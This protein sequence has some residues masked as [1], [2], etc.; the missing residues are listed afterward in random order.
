MI[1][2]RTLFFLFVLIPWLGVGQPGSHLD[3]L[4]YAQ[5]PDEIKLLSIT[6]E[7]PRF[8]KGKYDLRNFL[9]IFIDSTKSLNYIESS[10][11]EYANSYV[12]LSEV[13]L[14][15]LSKLRRNC[16]LRLTVQS[17]LEGEVT[18]LTNFMEAEVVTY[19]T[20]KTGK[21]RR[22]RSGVLVP[23][24][25]RY[26]NKQYGQLAALPITLPAGHGQTY[27]WQVRS[28]PVFVETEHGIDLNFNL[29][30]PSYLSNFLQLDV[31][32]LGLS[33]GFL[34]AV[35]TYH[36]VIF[37]YSQD[38]NY[39][40]FFVFCVATAWFTVVNLGYDLQYLWPEQPFAHYYCIRAVALIVWALVLLVFSQSYL[41]LPRLLPLWNKI[42][43]GVFGVAAVGFL[44]GTPLMWSNP[45]WG[46]IL[47]RLGQNA[48]LMLALLLQHSIPV[49]DGLPPEPNGV[50]VH[51][52]ER[53]G[54][55]QK[56]T[57]II[58]SNPRSFPN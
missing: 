58:A 32:V 40:W 18:W 4:Q 24:S 39:L 8:Q 53:V 7:D 44:V 55:I 22:L 28:Q 46:L 13:S 47:V 37:L 9:Y 11:P 35:G 33:L 25:E 43:W 30:S 29:L 14:V 49:N 12:P 52:S 42:L 19:T 26:F 2:I 16:W 17:S 34:I 41:Q 51:F 3:A 15:D 54:P 56:Q 6:M 31:M 20:T 23:A 38:W 57:T 10:S 45:S 21:V 1:K 36:F 27:Y 50:A 5:I 48:I